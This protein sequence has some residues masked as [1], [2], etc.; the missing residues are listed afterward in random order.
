[1]SAQ[2]HL[3]L[4]RERG[5][6]MNGSGVGIEIG[7]RPEKPNGRWVVGITGKKQTVGAIEQRDGVRCVAR[8]RDDFQSATAQIE[9]VALMSVSRDLPRPGS[10]G[11]RILS[12][13]ILSVARHKSGR[14]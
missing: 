7:F 5:Q 3:H 13:Q 8:A 1:M 6:A 9:A 12:N 10:V 14:V 4:R 11:F 2:D